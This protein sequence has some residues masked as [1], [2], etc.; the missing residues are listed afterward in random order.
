MRFNP[1]A[2]LNTSRT[3]DAHGAAISVFVPTKCSICPA[4]VRTPGVG[5]K[6]MAESGMTSMYARTFFFWRSQSTSMID[7]GG[8]AD[9]ATTGSAGTASRTAQRMAR[10]KEVKVIETSP[11][12]ER[13][14]P[15]TVI[16]NAVRNPWNR[17]QIRIPWFAASCHPEERRSR[18][19]GSRVR[20]P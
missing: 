17:A 4:N 12:F 10:V 2:R 7:L 8:M 5:A 18:D 15:A 11:E 16:P 9:C 1:K 13:R 14:Q 20:C 6:P 3:S 19:E